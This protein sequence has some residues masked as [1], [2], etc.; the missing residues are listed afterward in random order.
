M[1]EKQIR[2]ILIP[3]KY[4]AN[5]DGIQYGGT[6]IKPKLD[7]YVYISEIKL[8]DKNVNPKLK[9]L[10]TVVL[11]ATALANVTSYVYNKGEFPL[12]IGGD[13]SVALGSVSSI[14]SIEENLGV[15]WI[16]AHGDMNNYKITESGNIHGMVLAA[17]LGDGEES[18]VNLYNNGKKINSK[19]VVILGVRDL[20]KE[21]QKNIEKYNVKY[22]TYEEI[23]TLGLKRALEKADNYFDGRITKIHISIDLDSLDPMI[24]P[25]VSVP[26][27][28]GFNKNDI[29]VIVKHFFNKYII[30]SADIVEYN[31]KFDKHDITL[32]FIIQ[33]INLFTSLIKEN[34]K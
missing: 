31:P 2:K 17:L 4:G 13:H 21:E 23:K 11:T 18:L 20:D 16:D 29:E 9:N 12:I 33:L 8:D 1:K 27:I 25:G 10:S 19:N 32:D 7:D 6:K 3:F 22:L 26:V 30:T 28:K 5:I 24:I 15:I 14:A 34:Q